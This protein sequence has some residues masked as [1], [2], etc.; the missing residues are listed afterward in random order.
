MELKLLVAGS[1]GGGHV[2]QS[3]SCAATPPA[4]GVVGAVA[5]I[6]SLAVLVAGI[7]FRGQAAVRADKPAGK[8][9]P[10]KEEPK[11]DFPEID[12]IL[13]NLPPGVDPVQIKVI[14]EQ[15]IRLLERDRK[16]RAAGFPWRELLGRRRP[17]DRAG[18]GAPFDPSGQHSESRLG[19]LLKEP[20]GTLIDQLDLPKGQGM[21]IEEVSVASA[22]AKAGLKTNDILLELN[23]K[24]VSNKV[25]EVVKVIHE[26]K[27]NTPV[28][29]VVLRK[30]TRETIKGISLPEVTAERP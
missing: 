22:A 13:K 21:V 15:M 5:G 25:A 27:A 20:S 23:G 7:N 1:L 6:L 11:N 14:R 30:G 2:V 29:A 8:D 16:L 26:I 24:N 18:R 9:E 4:A 28:D 17:G 19:V 3:K 10:K 12:E